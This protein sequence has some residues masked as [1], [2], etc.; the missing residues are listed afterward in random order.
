MP[1]FQRAA[2]AAAVAAAMTAAMAQQHC[3]GLPGVDPAAMMATIANMSQSSSLPPSGGF[4]L[5]QTACA[6]A[7]AA[8]AVLP[9]PP[10]HPAP[11]PP[12]APALPP[13]VPEVSVNPTAEPPRN[14]SP[15]IPDE[16]CSPTQPA[17][18]SSTLGFMDSKRRRID[19][20]S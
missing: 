10:S 18:A 20:V 19:N 1:F 8:A 11:V 5:S 3:G 13:S 2:A 4:D 12:Q 14:Q 16:P 6:A 17:R 9:P 15:K 7:A